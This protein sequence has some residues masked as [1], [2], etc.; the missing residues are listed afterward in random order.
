MPD[1][2]EETHVEVTD[3]SGSYKIVNDKGETTKGK[4]KPDKEEIGTSDEK[5]EETPK[6]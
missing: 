4:G 1:K 2:K 3:A 6:E 5:I